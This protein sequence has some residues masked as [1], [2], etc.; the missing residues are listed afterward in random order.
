[1]GPAYPYRGGIAQYNTSLFQALRRDHEPT[2]VSFSRQYPAFLFP[3][4]TQHD[5]SRHPFEAASERLLD[6]AAP[7]TWNRTARRIVEMS[8]RAVVFQWWQ[9]FFGPA[10]AAV[11]RGVKRRLDIPA[12]FCCHNV[13]PHDR[14]SWRMRR[15]LEA[16]VIQRTFRQVDGFLVHTEGMIAEVQAFRPDAPIRRIYHPLYTFYSGLAD[17]LDSGTDSRQAGVPRLLFFGKVRPYKGLETLIAA[18]GILHREGLEFQARIAGEFYLD[19]GRYRALAAREGLAGRIEWWDRYIPNEEVPAL[20]RAADVVL[21]PY[22]EAT[23][24][25]VVP[26]AYQFGVPVIATRVGGLSEVVLEGRTGL[27]VP[28]RD[29]AALASAVRRFFSEG[30]QTEF[31]RNII[32]FRR[33]L[34]WEQAVDS[35]VDLVAATSARC[36]RA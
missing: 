18:L 35:L 36:I 29:P 25:G 10:F 7:P 12:I 23:Q 3:G 11:I 21:L 24:S 8:P 26:V 34:T 17:E 22:T 30:L 2:L 27:L 19:S 14:S 5:H 33:L 9:P 20:F 4:R 31:R 32:E 16:A 1:M 15:W 13:Y 28:P 6:P